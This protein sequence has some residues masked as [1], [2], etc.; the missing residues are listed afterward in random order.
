MLTVDVSTFDKQAEACA[1]YLAKGRQVAVDGRLVY[2]EWETEDG[3]KRSKHSVIGRV[4][5]LASRM[6]A[7]GV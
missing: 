1:R 5:L 6:A 2:R 7:I 4:E 3:T